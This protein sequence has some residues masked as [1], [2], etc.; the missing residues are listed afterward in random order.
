MKRPNYIRKID[1]ALRTHPV[2]ALLGPRQCGKTTL[3]Q[4]YID[5]LASNKAIHYFDLEDPTDLAVLEN[6]KTALGPLRGLIVI[7]EI[8][9]LPDLFP[10]LR[11]LVDEHKTDRQFLIL[12]SASRNLIRQSSES[13]AGRIAYVELTPFSLFEGCDMAT[14]HLRG[15]YPN[16]YLAGQ[17]EDSVYW[18]KQYIRTYLEQ[19]IPN[20]GIQVAPNAL[21]RF[22]LMLAHYHGQTFNASEI[23]KSLGVAD[24]TARKYLDILTGTFMV[25]T[26]QPWVE[27][28]KK[29]QVKTPKIYFRD[30]GI[31]HTLMGIDSDSA[32]LHHPKLGASW[33]GFALE[34]VIRRLDV[35]AEDCYFWG[36]HGQA[37]LDLLILQDG[38]RLGYEFKF[39]DAPRLS[40]SMVQ[41]IETLELDSLEVVYPGAKSY[42]LAEKVQAAPL[43]IPFDSYPA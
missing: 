41:A 24:T 8:Q 26:L 19:D 7:D 11:V 3:A 25:R 21:R 33:E 27:N 15:G 22:W 1:R 37:E 4:L 35:E 2:A 14:L 16:S 17:I 28:I 12:G 40:K 36:V 29:R 9:R 10:F 18:R 39:Q 23:A 20:L 43:S 31:Y 30:S 13:L 38:K 34:E 42:G 32:L 6:P 5:E